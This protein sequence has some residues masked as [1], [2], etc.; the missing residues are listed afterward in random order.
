MKF[1]LTNTGN[2]LLRKTLAGKTT[3]TF[4]KLQFGNSTEWPENGEAEAEELKNPILD[5]PLSDA[6]I[7]DEYI[8]LSTVFNNSGIEAGFHITEL[9]VFAKDSDDAEHLYAIGLTKEETADYVPGCDERVLEFEYSGMVFI[10]DSQN[11][12]ALLN[13]SLTSVSKEEFKSHIDDK[14]NPHK[15]TKYHVGLG[16]VPNVATNDQ[17]PTFTEADTLTNLES[18][19]DKLSAL[20]GKIKKAI[21][22]LIKHLKDENNPHKT[23]AKTIGAAES[24]H[25]HT[26]SDIKSGILSVVRG[27]SGKG[28]FD[29]NAVLIGNGKEAFNGVKGTGAF[30]SNGADTPGFGV[31]PIAFGGTGLKD[32]AS[33]IAEGDYGCFGSAVLPGGLLIQWGRV[34]FNANVGEMVVDFERSFDSTRYAVIFTTSAGHEGAAAS[35]PDWNV[36][37]KEK[38]HFHMFRAASPDILVSSQVADWIAIGRAAQTN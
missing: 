10:S 15:T 28:Q 23:T 37:T 30:F 35:T 24:K 17:L 27:G 16:D 20:F 3:I 18:G 8:I 32:G 29:K 4:T 31:L 6:E 9:G 12:N 26:T 34:S 19:I 33:F 14:Q 21:S 25:E 13:D 11:V 36:P 22:E 1:K 5:V 7:I 38:D 2:E